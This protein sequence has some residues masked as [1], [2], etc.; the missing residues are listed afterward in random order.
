MGAGF[1][2]GFGIGF[3][4]WFV[5]GFGAGFREAPMGFFWIN[6]RSVR[7][8]HWAQVISLRGS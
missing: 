4:V 5:A 7:K 3:G 1:G 8:V 2:I 6:P